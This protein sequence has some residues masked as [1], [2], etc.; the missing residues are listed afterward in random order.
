[1]K[2]PVYGNIWVMLFHIL[3]NIVSPGVSILTTVKVITILSYKKCAQVEHFKCS[4]HVIPYSGKRWREKTLA[5]ST[6]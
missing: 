6:V 1:M 2:I 5:N 4:Y 3:Y